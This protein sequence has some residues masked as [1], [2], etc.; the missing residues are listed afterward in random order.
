VFEARDI[1]QAFKA[2]FAEVVGGVTILSPTS[3]RLGD[4]PQI[5]A[6]G[7]GATPWGWQAQA[8]AQGGD[9]PLAKAIQA[10]LYDRCYARRP[11]DAPT[12]TTMPTDPEFQQRLAAAN[13]GRERWEGGWTIQQFAPHGQVF[14]RK[15]ER[16]RSAMPGA[17]I[18]DAT[19]GMAPQIGSVVMLRAAIEAP[20]AQPGYYF[21]FGETLDE[22][23]EQL[24]MMRFY[25]NCRADDAPALLGVVTGELNRFQVPFQM[26][27]PTAPALYGRADAVVL[28]VGLR[29]VALVLRLLDGLRASLPL[30]APTP[31]FTR[32]LWPGIGGAADPGNGESFGMHRCRLTAEGLVDAWRGGAPDTTARL[33]AVAAKFSANG[34]DL[35]R[36]WLAAADADPFVAPALATFA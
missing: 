11:A 22:L 29:Y 17:F 19:P 1:A 26:K 8:P 27:A 35:A 20:G 34:L 30:E 10:V 33:A 13:R 16:E 14:V 6:A 7:Q 31:L 18:S 15:G 21:A 5:D 25:F 24:S 12:P 4:G 32:P 23:A 2:E 36:P 3:F 28:Y 9:G